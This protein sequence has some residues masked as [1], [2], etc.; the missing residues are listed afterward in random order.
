MYIPTIYVYTY[1]TPFVIP[2]LWMYSK[3]V[4]HGLHYGFGRS[5]H[6]RRK[7]LSYYFQIINL[8]L[9]LLYNGRSLQRTEKLDAHIACWMTIG[10]TLHSLDVN[11]KKN[12]SKSDISIRYLPLKCFFFLPTFIPKCWLVKEWRCD[13]FLSFACELQL[14]FQLWFTSRWFILFSK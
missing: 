10:R 13:C 8:S 14:I 7:L 9:S 1:Q 12:S 5:R 2:D 3:T 4:K 11:Y 6:K